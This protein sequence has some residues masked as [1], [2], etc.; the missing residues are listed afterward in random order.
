MRCLSCQTEIATIESRSYLEMTFGLA[1]KPGVKMT[2]LDRDAIRAA[3]RVLH[4]QFALAWHGAG[5]ESTD[6]P[7]PGV[8]PGIEYNE[9][10][11]DVP[12]PL[13][14][15][16]QADVYFCSTR[17]LRHWF[18]ATV[19]AMEAMLERGEVDEQLINPGHHG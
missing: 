10:H 19:D 12:Q 7:Y 2:E 17:C 16:T 15:E 3:S 8:Y 6:Q 13:M 14:N 11:P 4:P 9:Q 5:S 1:R 18:N